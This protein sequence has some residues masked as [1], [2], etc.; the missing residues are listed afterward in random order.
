MPTERRNIVPVAPADK[1]GAISNFSWVIRVLG[2]AEDNGVT[3]ERL[4]AV[5][6]DQEFAADR[7]LITM[8]ESAR[9]IV[10]HGSLHTLTASGFL[11][12]SAKTGCA[13]RRMLE[14][15]R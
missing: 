15:S 12:V 8:L 11:L 7:R 13:F 3:A 6:A 1:M 9:A 4:L 5:W 2:Q 14:L 10:F